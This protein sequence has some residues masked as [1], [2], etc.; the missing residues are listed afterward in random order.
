MVTTPERE[1]D[2]RRFVEAHWLGLVRSAYLLVGD[3]GAAE[4]LVQQTLASVYRHWDRRVREGAPVA[5]VRKA[6][7]NHAISNGRRNRVSES[8]FGGIGR[9]ERGESLEGFAI[10][11]RDAYRVV[12]NRDLIVRGLRELPAQM[13]AVVVLRY[14]DDLTEAATAEL[15]GISVGSV[16]SQTSRGL[17][18]LRSAI[19]SASSAD[20]SE[21]SHR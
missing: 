7:V 15:L 5:Y 20:A 8:L 6:M 1:D 16:K 2:F 10:D 13:R 11:R 18:R 21:G 3:H 9:G 17:Q 14:F 19:A 4:D 12:D